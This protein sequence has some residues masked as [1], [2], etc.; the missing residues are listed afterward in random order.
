MQKHYGQFFHLELDAFGE[1]PDIRFFFESETHCRALDQLVAA[2]RAGHGFCLL[3]GE[4]GTGK[5]LLTRTLIQICRDF[6]DAAIILFPRC[7]EAELIRS[8]CEE[9]EIPDLAPFHPTSI[10]GDLAAL[11]AFLLENARQGRRTLLVIDEAQNLPHSTLETIRMLSNLES[12]DQKLLQILLTAQPEFLTML[13]KPELRQLRQRIAT[14]AYLEPLRAK[15]SAKYIQY[16]V[17]RAGGGNYLRFEPSAISL[18][19]SMS[20]GLP[21]EIN[22]IGNDLLE[23]CFAQ[24]IRLVSP[25]TLRA[26]RAA[27]ENKPRSTW[28]FWAR[29]SARKEAD[30]L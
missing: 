8:I 4:V 27:K 22:R 29:K 5:T 12:H 10:K 6:M 9:L 16:R 23:F 11:N 13:A 19:H 25:R 28:K 1:T 21:R 7:T 24:K 30:L 26:S 18:M 15:E 3:S 17:E 2:M 14:A 20:K